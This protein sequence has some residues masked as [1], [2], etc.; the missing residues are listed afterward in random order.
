MSSSSHSLSCAQS[1]RAAVRLANAKKARILR[2]LQHL[3]LFEL[4]HFQITLLARLARS[5]AATLKVK[6]G[7]ELA[8]YF[9][10]LCCESRSK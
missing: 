8:D 7:D 2:N 6:I 4:V 10:A 9:S 1:A 5:L 3:S